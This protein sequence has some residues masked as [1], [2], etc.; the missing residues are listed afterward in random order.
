MDIWGICP[1]RYTKKNRLNT[2]MMD[3]ALAE[4][5]P[6][7]GIVAENIRPEYGQQ[8]RKMAA[9]QK[10]VDRPAVI[11]AQY[12]APQ[13][14]RQEVILLG[15]AGQRVITAGEILCIAG[16]AAGLKTTQKNEYNITVLRGPSISEL[17]LSPEEI[18]YTGIDIPSV[19]VA[20]DQE[21]VDRRRDLFRHLAKDTLVIQIGGTT[22]PASKARIHLVDLKGQGIKGMDRALA[23]LAVLA[24]LK[25]VIR[26]EMLEAALKV[27]FKGKALKSSLELINRVEIGHRG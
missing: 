5:P 16:L 2:K 6:L 18:D 13:A 14:G 26:P 9:T 19:V 25:R 22:I 24:K 21:G 7:E 4:L 20:L 15:S 23:S 17:I 1:G 8:Y 27:R 3:D 10:K 11:K 12:E